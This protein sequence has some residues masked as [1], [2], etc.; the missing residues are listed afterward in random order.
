MFII[1]EID[2]APQDLFLQLD[3][4]LQVVII[5]CHMEYS[6]LKFFGVFQDSSVFYCLMQYY[7]YLTIWKCKSDRQL[8]P[9]PLFSPPF[10]TFL[11]V[12]VLGSKNLFCN[13]WW[14][15]FLILQAIGCCSRWERAFQKNK[16][17]NI[18]N[19]NNK[20]NNNGYLT[21]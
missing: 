11:I 16:I 9:S 15:P 20:N 3:G 1:Y 8:F 6:L 21:R 13:R 17:S 12:G 19:K 10:C 18:N 7:G 14:R 4:V 5:S 2:N